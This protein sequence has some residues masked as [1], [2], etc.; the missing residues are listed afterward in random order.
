MTHCKREEDRGMRSS[1]LDEIDE[2]KREQN[3]RFGRIIR[4]A[5]RTAEA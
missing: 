4:E 5:R 2:E 3:H 1:K